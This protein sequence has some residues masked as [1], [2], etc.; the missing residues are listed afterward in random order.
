MDVCDYFPGCEPRYCALCVFELEDSILDV[1]DRSLKRD[2]WTVASLQFD[3]CHVEHR[4]GADLDAAMRWA[5][6]AVLR[7]TGYAVQLKEKALFECVEEAEE[8]DV[9]MGIEDDD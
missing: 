8:N 5:E 1:I 6:R 4:V 2:G 7:E 9:L 3:G